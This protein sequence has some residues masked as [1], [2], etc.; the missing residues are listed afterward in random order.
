MTGRSLVPPLRDASA[1][2]RAPNET[3]GYELAGNAALFEG[4]LKLVRNLPP[5]GNGEWQLFDIARDPGETQNL[6]AAQPADFQRLLAAYQRF[7][8]EDGVLPLPEGYQPQRQVT[9]N[10][11]RRVILPQLLW[12]AVAVSIF[13]ILW[14]LIR[15]RRRRA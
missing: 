12:P 11:L 13:T 5:V 14:V 10:A 1:E 9:I 4:D 2:I 7:E 3:L 15:R 8:V 6:R